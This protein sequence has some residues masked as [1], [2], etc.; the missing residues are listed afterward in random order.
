MHLQYGI[1]DSIYVLIKFKSSLHP[2]HINYA[3]TNFK[4]KVLRSPCDLGTYRRAC[5]Y[6]AKYRLQAV[7]FAFSFSY[8][9]YS[10]EC[11]STL[12]TLSVY[13]EN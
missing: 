10:L 7:S 6:I 4:L 11:M 12:C 1:Q 5:A 8:C 3:E 9:P 13:T 2:F